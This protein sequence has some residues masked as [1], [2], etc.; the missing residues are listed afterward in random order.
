MANV[1]R[2]IPLLHKQ[3]CKCVTW[4][5]FSLNKETVS[6]KKTRSG[7]NHF[8]PGLNN[9]RTGLINLRPR[10]NYL[11]SGLTKYRPG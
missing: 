11:I 2:N 5:I 10:L 7:L 1:R 3:K 4:F 8:R 6:L 9:L